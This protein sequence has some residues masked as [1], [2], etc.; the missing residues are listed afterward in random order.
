LSLEIFDFKHAVTLKNGLGVR[1]RDCK[2]HPSI[3]R[4]RLSIDVL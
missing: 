1:Q 4:I 2:C 3:E